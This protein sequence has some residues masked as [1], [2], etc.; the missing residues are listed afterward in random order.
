MREVRVQ[1][2]LTGSAGTATGSALTYLPGPARVAAVRVQPNEA[3]DVTVTDESGGQV[4]EVSAVAASTTFLPRIPVHDPAGT[5]LE[6]SPAE[7]PLVDGSL[8]VTGAH[9]TPGYVEVRLY[10]TA[11]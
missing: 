9:G 7:P 6:G 10:L 3:C 1:L 2:P 4:L 8:T 5:T 11:L